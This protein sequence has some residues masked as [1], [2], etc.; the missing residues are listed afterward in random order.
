MTTGTVEVDE[1][2]GVDTSGISDENAMNNAEF[3]Y[4]W[5]WS[6]EDADADIAGETGSEY[7][8]T[9]DDA[10]YAFKL[11]FARFKRHRRGK[12]PFGGTGWPGVPAYQC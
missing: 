10:G 5:I 3:S 11:D 8:L 4:Q 1:T 7:T 9:E 2:L 12:P 6:A